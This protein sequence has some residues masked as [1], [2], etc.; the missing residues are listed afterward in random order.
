MYICYSQL[1]T[2][3][4]SSFSS[5][6]SNIESSG[7]VEDAW[8]DSV[9]EGSDVKKGIEPSELS[10]ML[11]ARLLNKAVGSGKLGCN[12][13]SFLFYKYGETYR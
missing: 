2:N 1:V 4:K 9:E 6:R 13:I 5:V 11:A 7:S 3:Y 12:Y 8:F 10:F